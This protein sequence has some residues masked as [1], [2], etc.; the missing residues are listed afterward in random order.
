MFSFELND[1]K[2]VV[3]ISALSLA[4]SWSALTQGQECV[5]KIQPIQSNGTVRIDLSNFQA[6]GI[7]TDPAGGNL[8]SCTWRVESLDSSGDSVL[9]DFKGLLRN[10]R[11][12]HFS[13]GET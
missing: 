2:P 1:F 12:T 9:I 10:S 5:G 8:D 6:N 7:S 4:S 13:G 11:L 3:L